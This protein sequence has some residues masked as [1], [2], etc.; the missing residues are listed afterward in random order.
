MDTIFALSSAPGKSGI[1]VFR[2][3]GPNSLKLLKI[4]TK[5]ENWLPGF[6][7]KT[8]IFAFKYSQNSPKN[9]IQYTDLIDDV[10][11]VYMK[12]PRSFTGEDV[13]EITTHGS[14]AVQNFLTETLIQSMQV[15]IA[16]P[17][18]FTKRA[19]LNGKLDLTSAEGLMDL[20]NSETIMQHR[21]AIR[22]MKGELEKI[23]N[24]WRED[25]IKIMSLFE[26][27]IDF[28]DEQIPENIIDD[29]KVQIDKI[30]SEISSHLQDNRRGERLRNG[31]MLTIFGEPNVG[32]S[33][34]INF[35]TKREVAIVSDIP[36]TTRDL[37]ETHID[38]GGYPFVIT[39]TAGIRDH[40]DDIIEIEGIKRARNS[41]E[42]SDVKIL[43][44][45]L[46]KSLNDIKLKFNNKIEL[47]FQYINA[48]YGDL[49]NLVTI[50]NKIELCDD[51]VINEMQ[52]LFS[53][54]IFCSIKNN[55]NTNLLIEKLINLAE[56]LAMPGNS[57][58][59]T[60]IRH[61]NL[62]SR[63]LDSLKTLNIED[64]LVLASE[65]IR[66]AAR[67]LSMIIGKIDPDEILGEI[68]SNFCI[69]K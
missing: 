27:Y 66:I 9:L 55:I 35:L 54:A 50:F 10:M 64:D 24:G 63:A 11:A 6:V 41:I 40:S 4:L 51:N 13:V 58:A 47:F 31:I 15:R 53:D 25:L 17:G 3:S 5:N 52:K 21:Q 68:F 67:S 34:L 12:S 14:I 65:D 30:I 29:I 22:Q 46:E 19:V 44:I 61:R 37:I 42:N 2:I 26:A 45:D 1:S 56:K 39:D 57:P 59:I 69:G 49:D 18:E 62:L 16:D 7:K 43:V 38:L 60:R 48:K 20:I 8:N 32:K 33:S 36:G 23:Y 28:P